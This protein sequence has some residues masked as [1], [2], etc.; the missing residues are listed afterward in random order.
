[1]KTRGE[2]RG[3]FR[4]EGTLE[5]LSVDA[6]LSGQIGTIDAEGFATLRPPR[7]GAENLLL[8]FSSLDLAALTTGLENA[9][10]AVPGLQIG[11]EEFEVV[12]STEQVAIVRFLERHSIGASRRT[13]AVLV[14]GGDRVR[15][16]GV[17][18]TRVP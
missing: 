10:S 12:L 6:T 3:Q 15:W 13:T 1:M 8:R 4:S 7:W 16:L 5:R 17:Q 2:V 18:E 14:P 9:H 11:I